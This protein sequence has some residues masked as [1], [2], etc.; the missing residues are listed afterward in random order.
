MNNELECFV[1]C[2]VHNRQAP[3]DQD[4]NAVR[5]LYDS[6]CRMYPDVVRRFKVTRFTLALVLRSVRAVPVEGLAS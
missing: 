1:R 3:F 2:L 4:L 6:L 5:H